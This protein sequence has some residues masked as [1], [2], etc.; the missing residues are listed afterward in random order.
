MYQVS[1][2]DLRY[3]VADEHTT[4]APQNHNKVL[5]LVPF[6]SG[7]AARFHLEIPHLHVQIT[8]SSG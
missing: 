6:K 1:L 7:V 2:G 8:W 4:S 3:L 5:M